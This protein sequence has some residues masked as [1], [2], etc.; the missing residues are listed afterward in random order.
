M[1]LSQLVSESE[2]DLHNP[3]RDGGESSSELGHEPLPR[4]ARAHTRL[5]VGIARALLPTRHD[6]PNMPTSIARF[7]ALRTVEIHLSNAFRKLGVSARA[8]L[9]AA[10]ASSAEAPTTPRP[11]SVSRAG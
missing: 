6:G 11:V 9:A 7:A 4:E 3:R 10:L 1:L 8:Q 2:F 5:E